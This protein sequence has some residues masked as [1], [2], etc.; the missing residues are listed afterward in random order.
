MALQY[1]APTSVADVNAEL[2]ERVNNGSL[3]NATRDAIASILGLD[4]AA[5]VIAAVDTGVDYQRPEGQSP[6]IIVQAPVG[7][8]GDDVT[9]VPLSDVTANASVY[10]FD[11]EANVTATFTPIDSVIV[12]GS[13]N[14][15]LTIEGDANVTVDGGQG[16]DVINTAN[17]NDSVAGGEGDDSISTGAGDDTIVA[18]EG[19][20]T[21]DGGE[22]FDVIELG[23][24]IDDY[25]VEVV[26]GQLVLT[27]VADP[28]VSVTAS[29]VEF[30]QLE[31]GSIA[32]AANEEDA[33]ALRL[34]Q[35]I[36]DRAAD[37]DGAEFWVD[38]LDDGMTAVDIADFFLNS[39]EGQAF[40]YDEMSDAQFVSTLYDNAFDR[41]ADADG[42]VYWTN[43]IANGEAT[44]ADVVVQFIG[45]AEGQDTI[46]NVVILDGLV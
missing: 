38:Q 4:T 2:D 23:G 28:S 33:Q 13:G 11:T 6:E 22:G 39:E 8:A 5:T 1:D 44:R 16:D 9:V 26:D 12:S 24:S 21:V 36:F 29:N 35:A 32:V 45:S 20:D 30:I 25:T 42:L 10:F 3:S 15:T 43:Q 17:G 34:Y 41:D 27:S 18:G 37:Q 46:D 7:A 19:A 14:D 31:T 40:G